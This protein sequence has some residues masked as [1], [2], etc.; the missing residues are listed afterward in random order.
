MIPE[1]IRG[2]VYLVVAIALGV[3]LVAAIIVGGDVAAILLA[4]GTIAGVG[5]TSLAAANTTRKKGG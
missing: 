2:W 3:A 4:L 5:G 1:H